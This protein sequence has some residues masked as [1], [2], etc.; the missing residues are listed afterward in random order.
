MF[1][2]RANFCC[3]QNLIKFILSFL[4]NPVLHIRFIGTYSQT[5]G[6]STVCGVELDYSLERLN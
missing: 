2:C 3:M 6:T 5:Y 4:L 1:F